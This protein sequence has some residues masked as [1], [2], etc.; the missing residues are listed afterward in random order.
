MVH[1][2][3]IAVILKLSGGLP[4][5]LDTLAA[6]SPDTDD[7]AQVGDASGTAVERFLKWTTD[8][9]RRAL[10]LD[11]ALPRRLNRDIVHLL[12]DA[13]DFDWLITNPFVHRLPDGGWAYHQVV[14]EQM[15]RYKRADSPDGWAQLH[16]RLAD[17]QRATRDA[18]GLSDA[19]GRRDPD[20]RA[21]ALEEQYHRL[22]A[23]PQA[24]L[25]AALNGFAQW[26]DV[27]PDSASICATMLEAAGRDIDYTPLQDWGE[28]LGQGLD[29]YK[30]SQYETTISVYDRLADS[31]A[32]SS[33][34]LAI[35]YAYRGSTK[36]KI[37]Q[38][39]AALADFGRAIELDGRYEWAI[40][41]RGGLYQSLK[42][43]DD[44][45][46]DFSRVI[47]FG[48]PSVAILT[49]R[50]NLYQEM[51][52]YDEALADYSRAIEVSGNRIGIIITRGRFYQELGRYEEALADFSWAVELNP[53]NAWAINNRARLHQ[54]LER[55]EEALADFNRAI[56]VDRNDIEPITNRGKFYQQIGKHEEALADFNRAIELDSGNTWLVTQRGWYH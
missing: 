34:N 11:A 23:R 3:I 30:E 45:V 10:A 36:S 13:P 7:P 6:A 46:K 19:D 28:I 5:L 17:H 1:E 32:L 24:Q 54:K 52:R 42:R 43:F 53:K 44:A 48:P 25:A 15:L 35:V 27:S 18:L 50:G 26:L 33:A 2:S 29:A 40:T 12:A 22:C 21:A 47:E 41:R 38:F 51:G 55:Y 8:P 4:L 56:E 20:W 14:R 31:G 16:E 9:A 49:R 39:D 37:E